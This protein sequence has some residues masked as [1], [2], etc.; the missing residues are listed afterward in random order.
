MLSDASQALEATTTTTISGSGGI[1]DT[2]EAPSLQIQ[3]KQ[4]TDVYEGDTRLDT[5][6]ADNTDDSGSMN[7]QPGSIQGVSKKTLHLSFGYF[8]AL[9]APTE[10][11]LYIFQ[12]PCPRR[13]LKCHQLYS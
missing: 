13:I 5:T 11:V 10:K 2:D 4:D 9:K 12:L 6:L 8:S 1:T 3:R 7:T